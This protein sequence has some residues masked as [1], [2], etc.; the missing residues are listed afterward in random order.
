MAEKQVHAIAFGRVQGV[1]FRF[2]VETVARKLKV[3]GFVKNLSDGT[4]EILAIGPEKTLELFFDRI[5]KGTW[6]SRVDRIVKEPPVE[7]E[8]FAGFSIRW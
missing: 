3:K 1:G 6:L 7:P 2:F 4:V 5:Q 8:P